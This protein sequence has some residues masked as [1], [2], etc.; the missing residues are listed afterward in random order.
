MI[1]G[2]PTTRDALRYSAARANAADMKRVED[3][4]AA[5][6]ATTSD[7]RVIEV[8]K[9]QLNDLKVKRAAVEAGLTKPGEALKGNDAVAA[10][11]SKQQ[12]AEALQGMKNESAANVAGIRA[13]TA[14]AANSHW[15]QTNQRN[16]D[17]EE[18]QKRV[19]LRGEVSQLAGEFG[20]KDAGKTIRGLEDLQ[21]AV[22]RGATNSADAARAVGRWV[23]LAQRD[24]RISNQDIPVFF[25]RIGGIEKYGGDPFAMLDAAASGKLQPEVIPQI[26]DAAKAML[27][28][29]RGNVDEFLTAGDEQ[30]GGFYGKHWQDFRRGLMGMGTKKAAAGTPPPGRPQRDAGNP[31]D[32]NAPDAGRPLD[33]DGPAQFKY[34]EAQV[35]ATAARN[36]L[37]VEK[38]VQRARQGGLIPP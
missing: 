4:V 33:G 16:D 15:E 38:S 2:V 22:G 37:D 30:F 27:D 24:S 29:E 3:E 35:R 19:A 23:Q 10:G 25:G 21:Q 18:R 11:I 1:A 6:L 13:E 36:G 8:L 20:I 12:G 14:G 17:K 32:P 26:L 31:D 9:G 7:P 34:T 28:R 5:R